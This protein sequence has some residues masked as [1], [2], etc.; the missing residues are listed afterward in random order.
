MR[1]ITIERYEATEVLQYHP[2]P[3]PYPFVKHSQ[4][5]GR[6]VIVD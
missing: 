1:I 3:Y 6:I 5:P 2:H 4:A